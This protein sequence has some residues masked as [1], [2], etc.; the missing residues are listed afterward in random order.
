MSY[1]NVKDYNKINRLIATKETVELSQKLEELNAKL[2]ATSNISVGLI[3]TDENLFYEKLKRSWHNGKANDFIIIVYSPNGEKIKNVNILGWNNYKLKE[4]IANAIMALPSADI[5]N[6]LATA[7]NTFLKG[8]LFTQTEFKKYNFLKIKIPSK[9]YWK[10]IVFQFLFFGYMISLLRRDPNTKTHRVKLSQIL[11]MWNKKFRPPDLSRHYHP[12]APRGI[13]LYI[14]APTI[15]T[16]IAFIADDD[17]FTSI[18][19]II[20]ELIRRYLF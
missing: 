10:L 15:A 13:F 20:E 18:L 8:P 9:E 17:P 11:E 12:L 16:Y 5:E 3:I 6:I 1:F 14:I 7:E 4:N 19:K 2:S